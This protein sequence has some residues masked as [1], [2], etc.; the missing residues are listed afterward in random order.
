MSFFGKLWRGEYTLP[1][2]FWGFYCAGLFAAFFLSGIL[3]I[4]SDVVDGRRIAFGI[5]FVLICIYGLAA[6][7]GVWRSARPYWVSPIWMQRIWGAL[8]RILVALWAAKVV[9]NLI[10]GGALA[11]VQRIAGDMEF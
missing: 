9:L 10:D 7:V 4:L 6:T 2:A 5:G 11:V 8:A 3:L 1:V